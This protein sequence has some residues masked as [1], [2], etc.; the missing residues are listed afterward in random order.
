MR[1]LTGRR[2]DERAS[3][4]PVAGAQPLA[5]ALADTCPR[6]RA[7]A[8]PACTLTPSPP[9]PRRPNPRAPRWINNVGRTLNMVTVHLYGGDVFNDK[10]IDTI[11]A[12][13]RMVG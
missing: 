9:A 5:R 1:P 8:G 12:D 6:S 11:L 4:R 10:K 3:C 7:C 13:R 2:C